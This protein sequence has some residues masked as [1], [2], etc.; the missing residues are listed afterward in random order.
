M[1]PHLSSLTGSTSPAGGTH[2]LDWWVSS[3]SQCSANPSGPSSQP[4][5]YCIHVPWP[6]TALHQHSYSE[7]G[8]L[9]SSPLLL[10][11]RFSMWVPFP[12][13]P[14]HPPLQLKIPLRHPVLSFPFPCS[15]HSCSSSVSGR[16]WSTLSDLHR[17]LASC[18]I[19]FRSRIFQLC[20]HTCALPSGLHT[21]AWSP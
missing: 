6:R 17:D 5:N 2:Q 4:N 7:L 21:T 1:A 8:L 18:I 13:A 12:P 16:L 14:T 19:P 15:L 3:K 9:S 10:T 20:L 11:A